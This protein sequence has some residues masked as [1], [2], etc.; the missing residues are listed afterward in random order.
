MA[1][2]EH[3]IAE[4]LQAANLWAFVH[5]KTPL[6][7]H[8]AALTVVQNLSPKGGED[9]KGLAKRLRKEL[10]KYH[11]MLPHTVALDAAAKLTGFKDWFEAAKKL[12][13]NKRLTGVRFLDKTLTETSFTDWAALKPWMCEVCE[14]C[15]ATTGASLFEVKLGAK[16][17][18]LAR[19]VTVAE[20]AGP[21]VRSDPLLVV[22]PKEAGSANWLHGAEQALEALRRRL[23]ETG[24]ATLDGVAVTLLCDN[25]TDALNSELVVM[26]SEHELDLGFEVARGDEVECWAQME[27]ASK[28][29][30]DDAQF[31]AASGAWRLGGRRFTFDVAT[32][33]PNEY[34][35]GLRVKGLSEPESGKLFRRYRLLKQRVAG[36]L[37]V[38]QVTKNFDAL[39]APAESYRVDLHRLLL[40]MDK[41]GLT[42]EGYCEQ[43]GEEVAMKPRLPTGFLLALLEFLALKDPNV[44]FARPTR[45]EL[46]L[47][48][49]DQLLRSLLP[50]VN[51]V[52]YRTTTGLAGEVKD[53]VKEAIEELSSSM[54]VRQM[55]AGT[56]FFAAA[57]VLPH[58]VY[59]ED[60]NE[61]LWTL[62][63]HGLVAYVG[64]LPHLT[65]TD[66]MKDVPNSVPFAFGLSVYLDIDVV[67]VAA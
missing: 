14:E 17:L 52:R 43:F 27:L 41:K 35:P 31:D 55:T 67:G 36:A 2:A 37:P 22:S 66:M 7:P 18:I 60:A 42:W 44:V 63:N 21:R 54:V 25:M 51:H 53:A 33:R 56:G 28:S 64:V 1:T 34:I 38:R 47:A 59:A 30:G 61:L 62:K 13:T 26:Q 50:R 65:P 15:H 11:V 9:L 5:S 23:E 19:P 20:E 8:R 32:I 6:F 39:G 12:E 49:D 4:Q 46:A 48:Q 16:Y 40:E 29:H 24:K 3:E 45:S 10:E 58:L 57:D